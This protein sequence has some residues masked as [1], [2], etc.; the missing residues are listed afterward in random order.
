VGPG[1]P[2]WL[3]TSSPRGREAHARVGSTAL[4]AR[5]TSTAVAAGA[6]RHVVT[7][8]D[9]SSSANERAIERVAPPYLTSRSNARLCAYMNHFAYRNGSSR[10][11][12]S[13]RTG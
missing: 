2:T 10:V 11:S 1:T 13:L 3:A 8:Q 5:P 4:P 12:V 6:C 9:A 7:A